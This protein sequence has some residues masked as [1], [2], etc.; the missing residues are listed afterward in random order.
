MTQRQIGDEITEGVD[1]DDFSDE[2]RVFPMRL[3]NLERMEIL[4][5]LPVRRERLILGEPCRCRS[6]DVAAFERVAFRMESILFVADLADFERPF[7]IQHMCEQSVIRRQKIISGTFCN[8]RASV[9]PHT[10]IDNSHM[11]RSVGKV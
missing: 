10:R 6:K 1:V 4:Y 9:T 11:H 7:L 8:K 2:R 5:H 3:S